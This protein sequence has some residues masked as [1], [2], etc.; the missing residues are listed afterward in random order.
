MPYINPEDRRRYQKQWRDSNKDKIAGYNSSDNR[1]EARRKHRITWGE[2]PD[3]KQ[4]LAEARRERY[5]KHKAVINHIQMMYGC[6]NPGCCWAGDFSPCDLDYHHYNPL[7]KD[8][9]VGQMASCS[10]ATI[11]KEINKCVVLCAICH[12]RFHSGL[13]E[14]S[15]QM[16]CR[17]YVEG[18]ALLIEGG[19]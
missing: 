16:L 15:E 2:K 13:I 17:V 7:E 19:V 3:V 12:R 10:L 1:R 11:A 14:L 6:M 5:N 9:V 18:D 4:R 8:A